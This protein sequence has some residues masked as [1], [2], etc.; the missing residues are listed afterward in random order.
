[1]ASDTR[2]RLPSG[3]IPSTVLRAL[4]FI[5]NPEG[6][7]FE[8]V[9]LEVFA[10]QFEHNPPY[11]RFCQARGIRHARLETWELIPFVPTAAFQTVL[12]SS[13]S[14]EPGPAE[15]AP[16]R[17]FLTSGTSR[18]RGAGAATSSRISPSIGRRGKSP[19]AAMCSPTAS[20]C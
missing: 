1:M 16:E 19:S 11:R 10:F 4:E 2:L 3:P 8:E 20:G 15:M 7:R 9:A 13:G 12:L 5:R 17:V 6:D 18:G 14:M